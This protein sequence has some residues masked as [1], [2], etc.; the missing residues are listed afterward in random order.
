LQ[1]NVT[2]N[3]NKNTNITALVTFKNGTDAE[4]LYIT[5]SVKLKSGK[6]IGNIYLQNEEKYNTKGGTGIQ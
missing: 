3:E 5:K 4:K 6:R 2:K 1:T